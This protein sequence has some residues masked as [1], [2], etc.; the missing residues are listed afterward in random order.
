MTAYS[1]LPTEQRSRQ[2]LIPR[3]LLSA[4]AHATLLMTAAFFVHV[5]PRG[6]DQAE[7]TRTTGIVL[8]RH[9]AG[10]RE[11]FDEE[12]PEQ[13]DASASAGS[14]ASA[15]TSDR[16][17]TAATANPSD[18]LPSVAEV[19]ADLSSDLPAFV[20]GDDASGRQGLNGDASGADGERGTDAAV[21]GK[22]RTGVFGIA[23][24]GNRFIY[25]FD[26]SG[27]M[28]AS[29]GRPLRAAKRELLASL[30]D[31]DSI[32]QFQIIFYNEKPRIFN[33]DG[34]SPTLA[35]GDAATLELAR[36]FVVGIDASGAT[37]HMDALEM[38]LRLNPDVVFFLTDADEPR[39]SAGQLAKISR[40]NRSASINAIEFGL[41][42]Q[43]DANNFLARLA[44]QNRGS[45]VYVDISKLPD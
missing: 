4:L 30:D 41:G 36:R 26:R 7:S 40:M 21:G 12:H 9:V 2:C 3:W 14:T 11:Y 6:N 17:S 38:A 20:P 24:E 16:A 1:V 33:P 5:R 37:Q 25:V 23:G 34:G 29:R 18:A 22:T 44:R 42:P 43:R 31:L 35:W 15:D 39:M 13:A 32:H 19:T 10:E 8:V 28:A 45:H 27:S